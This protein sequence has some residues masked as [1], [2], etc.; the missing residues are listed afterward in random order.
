MIDMIVLFPW[1][2]LVRR[3]RWP[4]PWFLAATL[5][6]IVLQKLAGDKWMARLTYVFQ[7]R[8]VAL[9]VK[10]SVWCQGALPQRYASL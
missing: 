10:G 2:C 8:A 7:C 5:L 1:V 3:L 4:E 9:L 6:D